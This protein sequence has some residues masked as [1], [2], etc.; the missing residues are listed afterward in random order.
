MKRKSIFISSICGVFL[1]GSVASAQPVKAPQSDRAVT[2]QDDA[3]QGNWQD[4]QA[5]L[6]QP[7]IL[8]SDDGDDVRS[9]GA[10]GKIAMYAI[11]CLSPAIFYWVPFLGPALTGWVV[12]LVGDS[13]SKR[14]T[15]PLYPI[16][17]AY[18]GQYCLAPACL[19][20]GY[21]VGVV[22]A[23][24]GAVVDGGSGAGS[25]AGSFAGTI[26]MLGA[27]LIGAG[28][29]AALPVIGYGL[30]ADQRNERRHHS[31]RR[32]KR[33]RRDEDQGHEDQA[34]DDWQDDGEVEEYSAPAQIQPDL[35][36]L[37]QPVAA[38]SFAF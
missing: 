27:G 30:S 33:A 24:T 14:K 5:D 22:L 1:L 8:A 11:S 21:F 15:S 6:S 32:H 36:L 37:S 9:V 23:T 2:A 17:G 16:L 18:A 38:P 28:L 10:G 31:R 3:A 20:V 35:Q 19:T 7:L 4:Q 29:A 13:M 25:L 34:S 12:Q 26:V